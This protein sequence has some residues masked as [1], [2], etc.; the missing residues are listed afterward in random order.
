M[1]ANVR[2]RLSPEDLRY[3][4]DGPERVR[5]LL[6]KLGYCVEDT[7]T[8]LSGEDVAL[9]P[10][11]RATVERVFLLA[12]QDGLQVL[13][14]ELQ[15]LRSARF[16]TLAQDL[17]KRPGHYLLVAVQTGD[18]SKLAFINPRRF[19]SET[20]SLKAKIHRL[21]VD[22]AQ[23]TR[24]DL[25]VLE[26]LAADG[27]SPEELYKAQCE[28]FSV[29]KVTNRF[30]RGYRE[31]FLHFQE[32]IPK[33]NKGVA[34]FR[35]PKYLHAFVQRLLGRVMFL[36]FLQ[37]KDWLAG[38]PR[39]LANQ[40]RRVITNQ[41][42]YYRHFLEPLFFDT[43][44]RRRPGDESPWGGIPYLNGGLFERDYEFLLYLPNELFD[45]YGEK[46]VLGF[47]GGYNFTVEEDTPLELDVAVDPEMLGKVFENMLE[48]EEREQSGTFYTP[49]P[50]VHFMC[51]AALIEYLADATGLPK[52]KLKGLFELSA[53]GEE[54]PDLS[55]SEA[56]ALERA[57]L[58]V[59]VLD[60]AVGTA[61]FLVGMLHEMLAMRKICERAKGV[62]VEPGSA[63]IAEWKR[64]FIANALYG[65]DIKPEA[66][67][68]AK[69][70]L[71]LSLVVDLQRDQVE[72][73]PN[74]D[75]KL[76][77]GDSLLDT[78]DGEPILTIKRE[79]A[80]IPS[81]VERALDE[82]HRL[83]E[84]FFTAEP[85][86]RAALR[87]EIQEQ[88]GRVVE[89]HVRER[90]KELTNERQRIERRRKAGK[91][92]KRDE[93]KLEK[94]LR[95]EGELAQVTQQV[96]EGRFMP[97]LYELHFH[98]AF[99]RDGFDIV[100]A[101]PPYVRHEKLDRKTKEALKAKYPHGYHGMADLYVYFY[102]RAFQLLRPGGLLAFISS[103]KFF[104]AGYGEG[105]R[106]FLQERTTLLGVIDFGDRPV[107][108]AT[109][110]PCIVLARNALPSDPERSEVRAL[111]VTDLE[112][113][114]RLDERLEGTPL[115]LK[116]RDLRPEGWRLEHPEILRLLD[117]IRAWGVPLGEYVE[118]KFYRG[119]VTGLNEAFVIDEATRRRLI[120]EDPKSGNY[121]A[122]PAGQGHQ[123][124]G[125]R[126]ARA[127]PRLRALEP[128]DRKIPCCAYSL[129]SVQGQAREAPGSE[130]G[131]LSL[132]C[133]EPLCGRLLLRVRE[134]EDCVA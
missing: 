119:I 31:L 101:N 111:V 118:G 115:V 37:K 85:E 87:E 126:L 112:E 94:L 134:A 79:K 26:Q 110:Y 21:V 70:R 4:Q 122:V 102:E 29:E 30:Y 98:E 68:I 62:R 82:L 121:K 9:S 44:N 74:L 5:D 20:G 40:Y 117:K 57:L 67:E 61:A 96:R 53:D 81:D 125:R 107:F 113:L 69:L 60:P 56:N 41:G 15:E 8:P 76:M 92:P 12:D 89:A 22:L 75:Y 3:C 39:F 83:K 123:A 86:G 84:R 55:V 80:L 131:A 124:L 104:R 25:D 116:Q 33:H 90:I 58:R 1:S 73:L 59:K 103:N 47:M 95:M 128:A 2:R 38:D 27:K 114:E 48:E 17:L 99:E 130:G 46:S 52:G 66:I 72:P 106:R 64:E 13:L 18:Y 16:R 6:R 120:E 34:H 50:I 100:L 71:W 43:L 28:A 97:F 11:N 45:P 108:D 54:E 88:L 49:R 23:P 93:Q 19:T 78:L 51:R 105:L 91:L 14:F 24:H 77:V 65:V 127:V 10:S 42:N 133:L 32:Q 132:V 129:A 7:L 109:A 36:Y 63:K 35:D